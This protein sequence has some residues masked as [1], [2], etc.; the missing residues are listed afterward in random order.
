MKYGL[1][2]Q[3]T[4]NIKDILK[5]FTDTGNHIYIFNAC[6]QL[7]PQRYLNLLIPIDTKIALEDWLLA[8]G[9]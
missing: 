2:L 1:I 4:Q 8:L 9:N 5:E 6:G 3:K 7:Y